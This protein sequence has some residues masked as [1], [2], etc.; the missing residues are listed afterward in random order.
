LRKAYAEKYSNAGGL[1]SFGGL[2][3]D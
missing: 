1:V 2:T 3:G